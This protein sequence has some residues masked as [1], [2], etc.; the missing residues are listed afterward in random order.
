M[1]DDSQRR[2]FSAKNP[3]DMLK[4]GSIASM[5]L[6][7]YLLSFLPIGMEETDYQDNSFISVEAMK[8]CFAIQFGHLLSECLSLQTF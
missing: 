5:G 8:S 4:L 3:E 7:K 2:I 1:V 6:P